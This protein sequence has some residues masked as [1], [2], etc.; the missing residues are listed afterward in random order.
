MADF[1]DISDD[2]LLRECKLDAFRGSGPGGQKRNKTSSAVRLT[3]I[4]TGVFAT[5]SE[6]RSQ[7]QNRAAA[8]RRLRHHITL[9]FRQAFVPRKTDLDI[10]MRSAEYLGIMG[11]ILDAL[12]ECDWSIS[13]AANLIAVSTA[14]LSAFLRRD[15]K[16]WAH[17]NQE[18]K[19]A[20]LKG[21]I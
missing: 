21:L 8:L 19:K 5:A 1:R 20:G 13:A 3:H 12:A 7:A 10:S 17:V 15:E 6:F 16:L 14:R 18:R 11:W 4:P 2:Q 9:E